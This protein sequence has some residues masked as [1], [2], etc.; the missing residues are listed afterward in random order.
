MAHVREV[1]RKPGPKY[2]RG[3]AYEV[4]WRDG[5][6]KLQ[7]TFAV[8]RDAE[9]FAL[10]VENAKDVGDTTRSLAGKAPTV[11]QVIAASM[12]AARPKLKP[13]SF[14][15]YERLYANRVLPRFGSRK[16]N[17]VTRADVQTWINSLV[18]EGLAPATVHH[19]YV[20]LRKA[21][22][23]AVWDR[24]IAHNPC[25]GVELPKSHQVDEG[26]LAALTYAQVE[27]VA[28]E[29]AF[30]WP[31]DLT[32]RFMAYT[33]LR[34]GELAGLRVRDVN[35]DAGHVCVRQTAQRIKGE[36]VLGTPKSRRSSRDVPLL[37][38]RLIGQLRA[39]KVQHPR[40]GDPDALFWPGRTPGS[41]R[42]DFDRVW[43]LA[44]FR[45]NHFKPALARAG[46][47]TIRVHDLRHTAASLWLAAGF[48][49]YQVSRWLGHASVVTTDTIYSHLYAT[50]YDQHIMRF[51]AFSMRSER[52]SRA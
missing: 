37:D 47:P 30:H 45:R 21:M 34:A 44:T 7:R 20:A 4:M 19:C 11:A 2:P 29:L 6:K 8:K 13:R 40:S 12:E 22:K 38:R 10:K 50:D 52:D 49:P 25:D 24:Q 36:W 41:H 48:P 23:H 51:E 27:A 28:G 43:D 3:V 35:L 1:A 42:V 17:A 39:Y 31:Y 46:L 14:D 5:E 32:V 15:S 26:E 18:G 9:R 33:G 16:V